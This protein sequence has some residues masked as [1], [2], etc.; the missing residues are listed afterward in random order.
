MNKKENDSLVSFSKIFCNLHRD[1]RHKGE[2]AIQHLFLFHILVI[3]EGIIPQH[4][5][6]FISFSLDLPKYQGE[7]F[8]KY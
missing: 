5:P 2:N 4:Q 7:I 6:L 1:T 8:R 3:Y